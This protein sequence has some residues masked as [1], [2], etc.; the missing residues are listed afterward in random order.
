MREDIFFY[1][2][3]ELRIEI[4]YH[5]V[6]GPACSITFPNIGLVKHFKEM[7]EFMIEKKEGGGTKE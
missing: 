6:V 5:P 2:E 3:K 1:S 4:W 7:L